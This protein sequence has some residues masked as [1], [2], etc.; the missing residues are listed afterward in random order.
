[1][2]G[3]TALRFVAP[4]GLAVLWSEE[5]GLGLMV[6]EDQP[7]SGE[8][9]DEGWVHT[10]KYGA[11]G[12]R[13]VDS[14]SLRLIPIVDP[15]PPALANASLS[16][17]FE[18]NSLR[19]HSLEDRPAHKVFLLTPDNQTLEASA[20][21]SPAKLTEFDLGALTGAPVA[22]QIRTFEKTPVL[23]GELSGAAAKSTRI[24]PYVPPTFPEELLTAPE[25]P[26]LA[27]LA[28]F[29][30]LQHVGLLLRAAKLQA[31][32]QLTDA[33]RLVDE[34]LDFNAQDAL[35][36]W[37]KAALERLNGLE[38]E[39]SQPNA[40]FLSPMEPMLRA[41]GFLM[42]SEQPKE[43]NPL[44]APLADFPEAFAHVAL[45][46]VEAGMWADAVRWL[47]EALRHVKTQRLLLLM[48]ALQ[49]RNPALKFEASRHLAEAESL[50]IEPPLPVSPLE[51]EFLKAL[52]AQFPESILLNQL[53][54]L[55]TRLGSLS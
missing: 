28:Q 5:L 44:L 24:A 27:R 6:M 8:F 43:P 41:E 35:L 47:D 9:T 23:T 53:T 55:A 38:D 42:Q 22:I 51:I 36:W 17:H 37:Q 11:L 30:G 39:V 45:V 7:F 14:F 40:Y 25:E 13:Q 10:P 50:G 18:E 20:D 26:E 15:A 52:H 3:N 46:L 49:T 2:L 4:D 1:L 31:K 34:A 16:V 32:E 19:I 29:P 21:L 48:A 12:P 54:G 33:A